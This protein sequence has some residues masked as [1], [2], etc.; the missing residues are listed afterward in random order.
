M[1][2]LFIAMQ[3]ENTSKTL[4]IL[5]KTVREA[6]VVTVVIVDRNKPVCKNARRVCNQ[7]AL[8]RIG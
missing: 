4:V 5:L 3:V 8:F 2:L 6:T 7:K 1:L